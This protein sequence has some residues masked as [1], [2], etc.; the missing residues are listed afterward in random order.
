MGKFSDRVE[1]VKPRVWRQRIYHDPLAPAPTIYCWAAMRIYPWFFHQPMTQTFP[2]WQ[3]AI[4]F[5]LKP[6]A[7]LQSEWRNQ[8]RRQ[9][10]ALEIPNVLDPY[11][12][13]RQH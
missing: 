3:D 5:A 13:Q 7:Q 6:D 12:H 1:S 4:A 10:L 9:M 2:S 11:R 8:M